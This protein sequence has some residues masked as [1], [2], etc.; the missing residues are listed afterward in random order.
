VKF[1][2]PLLVL[3]AACKP[4]PLKPLRLNVKIDISLESREVGRSPGAGGME[5]VYYDGFMTGT[6]KNT[7]NRPVRGL[8]I[9]TTTN[10][11][12]EVQ[13][14]QVEQDKEGRWIAKLSIG[15]LAPGQEKKVDFLFERGRSKDGK[16]R[17][18]FTGPKHFSVLGGSIGP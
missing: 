10:T 16:T 9:G 5:W 11:P 17:M 1:L 4:D 14:A 3:F 18:L 8:V 2:S 15:D 12:D 13:G 7:G 6:V